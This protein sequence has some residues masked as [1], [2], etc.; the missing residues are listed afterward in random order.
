MC[1]NYYA[2]GN[3][4]QQEKLDFATKLKLEVGRLA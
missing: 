1:Q 4:D 2:E 3:Q